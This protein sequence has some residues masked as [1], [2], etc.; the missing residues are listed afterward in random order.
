MTIGW[1]NCTDQSYSHHSSNKGSSDLMTSESFLL[2]NIEYYC[3]TWKKSTVVGVF[4]RKDKWKDEVGEVPER[5]APTPVY[6]L[7]VA[8]LFYST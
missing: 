2:R 6:C 4:L 1:T 7:S 3:R 8:I 5:I